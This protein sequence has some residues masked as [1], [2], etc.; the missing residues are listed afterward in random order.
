MSGYIRG[1]E[2]AGI[3][4]EFL[5]SQSISADGALIHRVGSWLGINAGWL[6]PLLQPLAAKLDDSLG[7]GNRN[8][9][10]R[11][12]QDLE[13]VEGVAKKPA[14]TNWKASTKPAS[15]ARMGEQS[16]RIISPPRHSIE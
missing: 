5:R 4:G 16:L 6:K 1:A 14:P 2:I 3:M 11:W 15:V 7:Y 12:W 8:P 13:I 9:H 10:K